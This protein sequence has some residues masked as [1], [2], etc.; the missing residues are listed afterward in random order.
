M[1]TLAALD[2]LIS[3]GESETLELKRAGETLCTFLNGE[4]GKVVIGVEPDGKLVGQDVADITLRDIAAILGCFGPAARVELSRVDFG[5]DG[6]RKR[7]E[8]AATT[9]A[10]CRTTIGAS[11]RSRPYGTSARVMTEIALSG[12]CSA[13]KRVAASMAF[14]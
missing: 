7:R 3:Q 1:T 9:Q 4:G 10:S 2:S 8:R 13:R 12:P 6:D 11:H 5:G 14:R